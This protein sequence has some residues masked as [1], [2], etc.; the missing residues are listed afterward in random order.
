MQKFGNAD[1]G[2]FLRLETCKGS[3]CTTFLDSIV[4]QTLLNQR[5]DTR[6]YVTPVGIHRGKE[7]K[8]HLEIET[9]SIASRSTAIIAY[10]TG[11][12][13]EFD[14][15]VDYGKGLCK[16]RG[17]RQS[18]GVVYVPS[19]SRWR[20]YV[21]LSSSENYLC[22]RLLNFSWRLSYSEYWSTCCI[23]KIAIKE[24]LKYPS[25]VIDVH[26]TL[27]SKIMQCAPIVISCFSSS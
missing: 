4:R 13:S 1:W 6:R 7:S 8:I 26:V 14:S 19:I 3:V 21:S 15:V 20:M 25:R 2:T 18:C 17:N 27:F 22:S 23:F 24:E 16:K 11:L 12:R 10:T 5:V 9:R